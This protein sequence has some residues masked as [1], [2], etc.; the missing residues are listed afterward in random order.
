VTN[1]Q[2]KIDTNFFQL[3]V[4]LQMAAMQNLGKIASPVS[5]EVERNL[6]QAKVSIDMLA[7]LDEKTKGNLTDEEKK[8]LE[9]SLY[10]LRMNYVDE[11]K[12]DESGT[13]ETEETQPS[14]EK[15]NESLDTEQKEPDK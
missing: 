12:K 1:E 13:Q 5:G 14:E 15:G 3:V 11:A 4:S 7:M 9:K 6:E 8:L 10:E 2:S